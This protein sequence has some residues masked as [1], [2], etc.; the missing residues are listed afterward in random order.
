MCDF[1]YGYL[2]NKYGEALRLLMTDTDCL[3]VEIECHDFYE[4]MKSNSQYYDTSDFSPDNP[5][6]IKLILGLFKDE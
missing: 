5:Y 6:C 3:C 2:K 4:D 1:Y